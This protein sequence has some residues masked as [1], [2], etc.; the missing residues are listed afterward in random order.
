ME[1]INN[2]ADYRRKLGANAFAARVGDRSMSDAARDQA[3]INGTHYT[4]TVE[5]RRTLV[6]VIRDDCGLDGHAYRLRARRLRRLH[7]FT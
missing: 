2:T 4:V 6:D 1:D 5:P 3:D 7:H